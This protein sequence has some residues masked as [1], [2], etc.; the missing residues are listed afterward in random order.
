MS[1]GGVVH[2]G[3]CLLRV[4]SA[5]VLSTVFFPL[6]VISVRVL[7]TMGFVIWGFYPRGVLST[8]DYVHW[9]FVHKGFCP[10]RFCL[11]GILSPADFI[12]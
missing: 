7:F 3:F 1:T 12:H 2:R 9:A 11:L 8:E 5:G 4:E 10:L 6:G